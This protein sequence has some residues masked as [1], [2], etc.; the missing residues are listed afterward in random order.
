MPYR[1]DKPLLRRAC[2][3]RFDHIR[4]GAAAQGFGGGIAVEYGVDVLAP[5][6]PLAYANLLG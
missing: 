3:L 4:R 1:F 5:A 6:P 2:R